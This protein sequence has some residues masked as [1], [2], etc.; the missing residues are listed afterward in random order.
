MPSRGTAD[1]L[2]A[3]FPAGAQPSQPCP[4]PLSTLIGRST[5]LV[6]AHPRLHSQA[7]ALFWRAFSGLFGHG[8]RAED[9]GRLRSVR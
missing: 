6:D 5:T 3:A 1:A 7:K 8:E 9:L 4:A 2:R